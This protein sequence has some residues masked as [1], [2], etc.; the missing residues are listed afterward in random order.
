MREAVVLNSGGHTMG[1]ADKDGS[2]WDGSFTPADDAWPTPANKHLLDLLR[3]GWTYEVVEETSRL[4]VWLGVGVQGASAGVGRV[5]G[6]VIG[7][8]VDK[9]R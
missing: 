5:C 9:W 8:W 3:Y 6:C 4:Q 7:G 1:G 2:G